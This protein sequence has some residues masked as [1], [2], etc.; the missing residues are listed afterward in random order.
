MKGRAM[1]MGAA[2]LV[3]SSGVLLSR[4]LGLARET[5]L[6]A[7]IGVNAVGDVYRAAFLVPDL[8]NY[9]LAGGY[10]TITFV[11]I[12]AARLESDDVAGGNQAFVAVFRVVTG[13]TIVLTAVLMVETT[14]LLELIY[15]QLSSEQLAEVIRLTRIALPAQVFFV[16]GSLLM[17]YQYA[18][19]RF[20][21]PVAA[22]IVYNLAIIMGGLV[23]AALAD[24][25]PADGFVWGALVGA[26]IGNFSIQ[27]WGARRVGL[28][29]VK[30]VAWKHPA[31]RTYLA[32]ALPLMLAQSVAVLDE[33]FVRFF[34]QLTGEGGISALS[35][36]RVLNMVP[37]GMV[38]QAAGVAAFPFLASLAAAG[39][40]RQLTETTLRTAR[41]TLF[42]GTAAAAAVL[43]VGSP[44]VR[45]VF[46]WGAF[47][48]A[49]S[50]TVAQLLAVYAVAI[51]AWGLHQVIARS[52]YAERRMW[53][54][55]L[56]GTGA[57][58]MAVVLSMVMVAAWD[59]GGLVWAS[60]LSMG[61]YA[62][63]LTFYWVRGR[64]AEG[65]RLAMSLG[66]SAAAGVVAAGAGWW[67]ARLF[68]DDAAWSIAE[69]LGGFV[70]GGA[71]VALVFAAVSWWLG[72][73]EVRS[74]WDGWR[75]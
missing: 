64:G 33:Q 55:V 10:L 38:A 56:I 7:L 52:F 73:R 25:P 40:R 57:A 65:N 72:S 36:A 63:T 54:P 30:G 62:V 23:G 20:L 41:M 29:L 51:P 8:L 34:G 68:S 6:A 5:M 67:V 43:A 24:P 1:G 58:A 9:L 61:A 48:T 45:L 71:T 12:L 26:A 19:R 46:Q 2:A 69:A 22:P 75:A 32:L 59:A 47:S 70:A 28:R 53:P 14:P 31:V 39:R 11:P 60:V 16:G 27:W 4:V 13:L 21:V 15:P 49:D 37:V 35:F 42:L 44:G 18:H 50:A 3:V 66:R 17:A 74:L